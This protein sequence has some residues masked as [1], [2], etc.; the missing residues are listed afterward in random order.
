[1]SQSAFAQSAYTRAMIATAGP[2]A[3]EAEAFEKINGEMLRASRGQG[4]D[5]PAYVRALSRNLSLWTILAADVARNDNPLRGDTKAMIWKI[6][7]FVR[8]RTQELMQAGAPADIA[9]LIEINANMI[10]GLRPE[11]R[12]D[13]A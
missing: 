11:R 4:D 10:A 2:R 8:R 9:A 7:A 6:A 5:H 12:G 3:I 1:M 13:P